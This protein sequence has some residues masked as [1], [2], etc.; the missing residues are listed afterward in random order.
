MLC[1]NGN[2]T[3]TH[4]EVNPAVFEQVLLGWD[5]FMVSRGI[6]PAAETDG[7]DALME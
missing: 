3:L 2:H 1:P 6:W 4:F 5:S 7:F